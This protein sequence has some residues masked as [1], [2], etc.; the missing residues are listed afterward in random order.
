MNPFSKKFVPF[1]G[2]ILPP[3]PSPLTITISPSSGSTVSG[4]ITISATV[5]G[6]VGRVTIAGVKFNFNGIQIG[7][8]DTTSP[9]STTLDTTIYGSGNY[10]ITA[11]VRDSNGGVTVSDPVVITINNVVT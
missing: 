7:A 6:L 2:S 3:E 10:T 4:T 5:T 11:I 1:K 9:Y 8:E